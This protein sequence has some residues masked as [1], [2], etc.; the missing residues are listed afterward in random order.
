M[1][2]PGG[3]MLYM[4]AL[5]T[6][7]SLRKAFIQTVSVTNYQGGNMTISLYYPSLTA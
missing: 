5:M 2:M 4:S 1:N 7:D 3:A 6:D